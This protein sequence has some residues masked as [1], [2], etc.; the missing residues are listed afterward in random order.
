MK[1]KN[2]KFI[3]PYLPKRKE[4][5]REGGMLCLRFT[6]RE[7]GESGV[8]LPAKEMR[9]KVKKNVKKSITSHR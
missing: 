3:P 9:S 1:R 2:G 6:L 4:R 5:E 7:S 8:L